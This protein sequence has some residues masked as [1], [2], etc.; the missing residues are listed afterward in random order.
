MARYYYKKLFEI[1]IL[2]EYYLAKP[3]NSDFFALTDVERNQILNQKLSKNQYNIWN[4]IQ[5][6][7]TDECQQ[8][9][10]G[11][12]IRFVKTPTGFFLGMESQM[13]G[14]TF[15]PLI[16]MDKNPSFNFVV[17]MKNSNF[18]NFT[19][20]KLQ[21][22]L[23]SIFYFTNANPDGNKLFPSLSLPVEKFNA[24]IYYEMGQLTIIG[25]KLKEAL[26]RTKSNAASKWNEI[27]SIGVAH[28]G[29]RKALPA[30]FS[31]HFDPEINEQ[32]VDFILK[33][34]DDVEVKKISVVQPFR[35]NKITLDFRADDEDNEIPSGS[36][37]LEVNG[38][39]GY[40][41]NFT[42]LL[43][44]KLVNPTYFGIISIDSGENDAN[45]SLLSG[46]GEFKNP[47]PTFEIRLKS[48]LTYWRYKSN[49]G[50]DLST[51][52]TT[53]PYLT[54]ASGILNSKKPRS[55]TFFPTEF[56]GDDP[57]TPGMNERI[58]LP[59]PPALSLK[60][61]VDGKIYSDI[62][63]SKIKDLINVS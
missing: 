22:N 30:T 34:P 25:S 63:I 52:P 33:T 27:H 24:K 35:L 16:K 60:Q 44:I 41:N 23:P 15:F 43:D 9:L 6:E 14:S 58:F 1:K 13:E 5:I 28:H 7:P 46:T 17:K 37:Q 10:N 2:H 50:K 51:T 56:L 47:H 42:I 20:Y 61:E 12:Q 31:F 32:Q 4:D 18:R 36:Y 53:A 3:D 11:Y 59:N 38:G 49:E 21:S 26:L 57:G 54:T 48:R 8:L 55:L 62:F 40:S 39:A 45:Y 29:D 19:R